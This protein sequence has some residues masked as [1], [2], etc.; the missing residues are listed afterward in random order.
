MSFW[1]NAVWASPYGVFD[2][3]IVPVKLPALEKWLTANCKGCDSLGNFTRVVEIA[4]TKESSLEALT[5]INTT[6]N[7]S[8]KYQKE[9]K[10]DWSSASDY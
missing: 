5:F 8:I 2:S 3:I 6:V 1:A 7:Q 4:E 9:I 10:D